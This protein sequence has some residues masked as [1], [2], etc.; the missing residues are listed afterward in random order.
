MA[1]K[2]LNSSQYPG[3]ISFYLYFCIFLEMYFLLRMRLRYSE[4]FQLALKICSERNQFLWF[5]WGGIRLSQTFKIAIK[6]GKVTQK[7]GICNLPEV[8]SFIMI[9]GIKIIL[10]LGCLSHS[11]SVL[12]K[13]QVMSARFIGSP[14]KPRYYHHHHHHHYPH[15]TH[16]QLKI[17][18]LSDTP[19]SRIFIQYI[20]CSTP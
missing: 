20:S 16:H 2:S 1:L 11:K 3:Q 17:C 12:T 7:E 8:I 5:C 10:R 9:I 6:L 19:S 18:Y 13:S 14:H 4:W 15:H